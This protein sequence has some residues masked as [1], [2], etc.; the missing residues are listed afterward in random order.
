MIRS[1]TC[2]RI[3]FEDSQIGEFVPKHEFSS[4]S[5]DHGVKAWWEEFLTTSPPLPKKNSVFSNT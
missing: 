5:H 4:I 1:N 3:S 2:A